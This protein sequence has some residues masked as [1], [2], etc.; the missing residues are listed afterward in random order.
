MGLVAVAALRA[1]TE[2]GTVTGSAPDDDPETIATTAG[3]AMTDLEVE[4]VDTAGTEVPRGDTGE[5]IPSVELFHNA[6]GNKD[7]PTGEG[8][9]IHP[10]NIDNPHF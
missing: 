2:A 1:F 4:I 3:R 7:L 8:K 6:L 5:L 10:G 9:R